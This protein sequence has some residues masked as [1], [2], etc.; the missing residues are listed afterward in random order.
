VIGD[1]NQDGVQEPAF[2]RRG[3]SIVMQQE[4]QIGERGLLHEREDVVSAN[5]EVR[6]AGINDCG[7]PR[8][9]SSGWILRLQPL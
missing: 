7:A 5:S 1:R 4:N 3:Q 6:R 8:V 2:A 9:H